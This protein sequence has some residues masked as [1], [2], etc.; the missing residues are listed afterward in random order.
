[1]KDRSMS[2]WP[3][4]ASCSGS[5]PTAKRMSAR[6]R[7]RPGRLPA[8]C[9]IVRATCGCWNMTLATRCAFVALVLTGATEFS[10]RKADPDREQQTKPPRRE[11]TQHGRASTKNII[12]HGLH[13]LH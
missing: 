7:V 6:G 5:G 8:A 4:S 9:L 13:G 11:E 10:P 2:L 1:M 12:D 3:A